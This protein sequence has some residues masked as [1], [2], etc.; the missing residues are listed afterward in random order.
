MWRRR[1]LALL[2]LL[3]FLIVPLGGLQAAETAEKV[4]VIKLEGEVEA[5]LYHFLQRAFTEAA[6]NGASAII[7]ELNTPGGLVNSAKD[8]RDLIYD[9]G[10]P[11]YAYVRHSALSAGAF[12]A[13]SCRELYMAPGSTIGA[14]QIQNLSGEAVDEKIISAWE[15][16]MRT[17]AQNQS[18]DPQ[19]AAAMVRQEIAIEGLVS[20][21]Q[22][23]T[24]TSVEAEEIGFTDGIFATR[25]ELLTA[26]GLPGAAI[27]T[28]KVSPAESLARFVAKPVGATL[29]LT[30]GLAALVIEIFMAGFGAAGVVSILAFALYFGGSI[31]AG[32]AGNEV[33]ILFIAGI[34]LMLIE[35]VIPNFGVVGISGIVAMITAIILSA[36]TAEQGARIFLTSLLLTAAVVAVAF[37]YLKRS[38]LW[39][40]IILQYAE[41]KERGY[42]GPTDYSSLVGK[43]G[44]TLTPLRPVGAV[45][46]DGK[47]ID[48]VSEGNFIAK[49]SAVI[50]V[51]V[52]GTRVIV[53]P[54]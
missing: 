23:L 35:A 19:V 4:Y 14:A 11:V 3:M 28:V 5:G 50:V 10:V 52:E 33:I 39:S 20:D 26:L 13:L 24:L 31:I 7:M 18:K 37:R 45:E 16:E 12:L 6:D 32:F 41:T 36:S 46:I 44:Q 9:S 42:V 29:L 54:Q 22:L 43:T 8:I 21:K 27:Y 40:Q 51:K 1:V 25:A 30:I 17:V 47:R 49:S 38:K 48:V 15:A 34:I 53:R 2:L